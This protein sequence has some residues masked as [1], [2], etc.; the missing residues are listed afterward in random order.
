MN[1][2]QDFEPEEFYHIYNK[3]VSGIRLFR[4]DL[5]YQV[6]LS[7]FN[8]YLGECFELYAYV[9]LPNHFHLLVKVKSGNQLSEFART[10]KTVKSKLFL[11]Q[12]SGLNDFV[13]DQF[14][15]WLSSYTI[16]YKNKYQHSGSVMMKRFKRIQSDSIEKNIYWLAYI[17]HNPIHHEYCK[18]YS[19]WKYSSYN[20]YL[21]TKNTKLN[22]SQTLDKW[23]SSLDDFLQYHSNF[24]LDHN[25]DQIDQQIDH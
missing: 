13:V 16:T 18:D 17:H 20:T 7:R 15:R 6:F 14:K 11:D 9:L 5:D 8:T 2:W 19:K 4:E 10:Q 25:I 21:T 1:Y 3:S 12:P 24:K 23:F 22:R